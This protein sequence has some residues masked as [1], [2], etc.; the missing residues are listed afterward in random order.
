[1][2]SFLKLM[3][4]IVVCFN[5]SAQVLSLET[6][7]DAT[8]NETSGLL[9]LNNTL[10]THN[11]SSNANAL[12]DIDTSTG[13]VTRTVTINNA[14]NTDWEDIAHDDTYIY[15][16]DFGNNFGNRNDLKIYRILIDDY[17]S[18]TAITA[19]LINFSYSNQTD[20][21]PSPFATNFDAEG[22]IHYNDMLYIF[23]KNWIDGKTNVYQV[24]KDPGSYSLSITDTINAQGLVSGATYNAL[25][26]TVMLCGY[27]AEGAFVIELNAFSAELFSNGN[28][29]KTSLN[30]PENYSQQIEAITPI[31]ASE[32]YLSAEDNAGGASGLYRFSTSTL[33]V[34]AQDQSFISFYPNPA[35]EEIT[36]NCIDCETKI[37]AVT[38]QVVKTSIQK[39]IDISDLS[40]GVYWIKILQRGTQTSIVK[41][42][43]IKH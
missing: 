4:L 10:I 38:G 37:Y 36:L 16:G 33:N 7:L 29:I 42:L 17:F 27:N 28:I 34:D 43:M 3:L 39:Q 40:T 20:F 23:S 31:N 25:S 18:S 30:I 14:T 2:K 24:P 5:C 15:I 19:E 21:S 41:Q 1:M 32:Y 11:D 12:Y 9:Y 13:L 35:S 26:D 8:V 22:L 6:G